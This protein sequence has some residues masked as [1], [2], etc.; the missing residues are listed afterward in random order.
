MQMLSGV[1]TP[2]WHLLLVAELGILCLCQSPRD[3]ERHQ[4]DRGGDGHRQPGGQVISGNPPFYNQPAH[5]PEALLQLVRASGVTRA[6]TAKRP[7]PPAR[8]FDASPR[9][10]LTETLSQPWLVARAQPQPTYSHLATLIPTQEPKKS[11]S[12]IKKTLNEQTRL[13]KYRQIKL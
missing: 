12:I 2:T 1:R 10:T 5:H 4:L 9:Q 11:Q 8:W 7:T 3:L 13:D 6:P